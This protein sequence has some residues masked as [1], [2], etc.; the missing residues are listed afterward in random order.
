M[1]LADFIN[2]GQAP[3]MAGIWKS[4]DGGATWYLRQQADWAMDVMFDPNNPHR[5]YVGG[6]RSIGPWGVSTAGNW[7]YGG[8]MYSDDAGANT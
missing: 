5:A 2:N 6:A 4:D 8:F 1:L 7:G 3:G